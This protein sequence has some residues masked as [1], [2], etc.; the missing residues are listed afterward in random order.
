VNLSPPG[1]TCNGSELVGPIFGV[2][3]LLVTSGWGPGTISCNTLTTV[4]GESIPNPATCTSAGTGGFGNAVDLGIL[5]LPPE[6]QAVNTP[7]VDP[8]D[9]PIVPD[10]VAGS[11]GT[12]PYV[13]CQSTNTPGGQDVGDAYAVTTGLNSALPCPVAGSVSLPWTYTSLYGRI[14][15]GEPQIPRVLGFTVGPAFLPDGLN[16]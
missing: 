1:I 7:C 16:F 11:N 4:G 8:L 12:S 6:A 9:S 5:P 2:A 15:P 10:C 3:G 14:W 13:P